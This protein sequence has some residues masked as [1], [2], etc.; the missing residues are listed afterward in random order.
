MSV[1]DSAEAAGS[2]TQ[3]A[4]LSLHQKFI[5]LFDQGDEQGPFGPQYSV[6]YAWRLEGT[7]DV[8]AL[9]GALD[10]VVAR[11]E[12]LRTEIVRDPA[13]P[14]QRI[15]PPTSPRLTVRNLPAGDAAVLDETVRFAAIEDLLDE[16]EN[17]PFSIKEMPLLR[18]VLGR[19]DAR[20][21]VLVLIAHHAAADGWSMQVLMGELANR[22]A[23]R[24]GHAVPELA[25]VPQ[26]RDY[27]AWEQENEGSASALRAREFWRTTYRDARIAATRTDWPRSAGRPKGTSWHRFLVP[28]ATA[29]AALDLTRQLRATPFMTLLAA[30]QVMLWQQTGATD[31]TVPMFTPGRGQ[32][33]FDGTVGTFHNFL[34]VRTDLAGC[35]TFRQV[36]ERT[37]A[38][39]LTAYRHE[40][41]FTDILHEVP[42]LMEPVMN[43]DHLM[44]A[45]QVLGSEHAPDSELVGDL[46]YA[47]VR[48]RLRWQE[49]G[50]D[51][52]DGSLWTLDVLPSREIVGTVGFNHNRWAKNTMVALV[53]RYCQV[54]GE[55]CTAPDAPLP[56][57]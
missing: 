34:P 33:R 41:A 7:V 28:A 40:I 35:A 50:I 48:R 36:V 5:S 21:S 39:C 38:A 9:Q 42:N 10:D 24:R 44:V 15:L 18:A 45:I 53:D 20:D 30:Y 46:R 27:V 31:S 6:T 26:Y 25:D 11:H 43:D 54:L 22:Y 29:A 8:V 14:H 19:F 55:L 57:R 12:A 51:V 23:R 47:E 1:V 16:I 32:T 37:R 52:P 49:Q 3:R 4:P 56:S 13:D 17:T 2:S